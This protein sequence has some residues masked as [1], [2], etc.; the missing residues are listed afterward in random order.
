MLARP[1]W[2]ELK[3]QERPGGAGSIPS[4][5]LGA[6]SFFILFLSFRACGCTGGRAGVTPPFAVGMHEAPPPQ[7][8]VS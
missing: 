6:G 5:F 3:K 2:R 7:K 8:E 4:Y 1:T